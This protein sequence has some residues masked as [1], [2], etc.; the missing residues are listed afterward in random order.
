MKLKHWKIYLR[1]H[2]NIS[3]IQEL[4]RLVKTQQTTINDQQTAINELNTKVQSL[5]YEKLLIKS[6]LNELLSE[7]G[8]STI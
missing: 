6:A 4:H 8:K 7:A 2:I 5:E 3:A 1:D